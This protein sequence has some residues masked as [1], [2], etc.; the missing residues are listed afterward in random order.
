MGYAQVAIL[1]RVG[2]KF[3]RALDLVLMQT[4]LS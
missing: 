3:G 4:F 1:Q 2:H